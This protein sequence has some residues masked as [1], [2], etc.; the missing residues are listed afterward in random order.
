[1][2]VSNWPS[3]LLYKRYESFFMKMWLLKFFLLMNQQAHGIRTESDEFDHTMPYKFAFPCK[4]LLLTLPSINLL[5]AMIM[6]LL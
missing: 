1:M 5:L 6:R 2:V 3:F 4:L